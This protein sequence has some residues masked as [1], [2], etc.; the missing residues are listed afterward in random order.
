MLIITIGLAG[1]AYVYISGMLT[2]KMEKTISVLDASCNGTAITVVVANDGTDTIDSNEITLYINNQAN[3]VT[4]GGPLTPRNTTV[5]TNL[6]SGVNSG[7]SNTVLVVSP[8]NSVR[9]SVWCS[10]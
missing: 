6:V 10:R 8:S 3:P 9:E 1:T 7:A 4:L 5:I 2:G